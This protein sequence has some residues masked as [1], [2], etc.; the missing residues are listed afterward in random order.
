MELVRAKASWEGAEPKSSDL[1]PVHDC[2]GGTSTERAAEDIAGAK[3]SC[4]ASLQLIWQLKE[5][6]ISAY[7]P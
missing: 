4:S 7:F 2:A 6:A 1:E 3:T 5:V